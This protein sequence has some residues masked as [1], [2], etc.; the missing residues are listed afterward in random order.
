MLR[1]WMTAALVAALLVVAVAG[2]A[3]A[4]DEPLTPPVGPGQGQGPG[5]C[6]EF[7]DADGDGVCD[8]AGQGRLGAGPRQSA[9]GMQG[10]RTGMSGARRAG[11][12][13]GMGQSMGQG[14]GFV[15]ANGDGQC[16]LWQDADGD[17]VNDNAPRDG[18]GNR[19]GHGRHQG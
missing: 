15:D 10:N 17:G 5:Q 12:G 16:D 7:V 3:M 14:A 2:A 6:A 9:Q 19:R 1:K 11:M 4:A 8:N 13:Q 18:T